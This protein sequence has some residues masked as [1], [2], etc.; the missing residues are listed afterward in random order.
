MNQH[1]FGFPMAAALALAACGGNAPQDTPPAE[2]PP[3][4]ESSGSAALSDVRRMLEAG[5]TEGVLG[6]LAGMETPEAYLLAGEAW[7]R[8]AETAPLPTPEALPAGSPKGAVP[9]TPEFKPEELR[10][11]ELLQKAAAGLPQDA[12]PQLGIARLLTPHALRRYDAAQARLRVPTVQ[13]VR[14][15]KKAT[16]PPPTPPPPSGPDAGPAVVTRAYR[17]AATLRPKDMALLDELYTFAVRTGQLED[18]DWALHEA[19]ERDKENPDRFVRYGDFLFQ[20]KKSPDA[21]MAQYRQALIWRADDRAVKDKIG[22]IYLQMGQAHYDQNELALAEARYL[23]A[24]KWANDSSSE[25]HRRIQAALG[26]V[27]RFRQ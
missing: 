2:A 6:R 14:R 7:A 16:P 13:P 27:K 10:S 11:L 18:A 22:E 15:G 21:A 12:R 25:T 5:D 9:V 20:V 23:D 1:R 24:L 26:Q 17:A 8:K 3:P 19:V 4:V